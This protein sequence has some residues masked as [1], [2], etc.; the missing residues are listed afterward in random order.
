MKR[1][2]SRGQTRNPAYRVW[3]SMIQRC[4][5]PTD[6]NYRKYGARGVTVCDEWRAS[7]FAFLRDMGERPSKAHTLDRIDPHGNYEPKNCRWATWEQ[8][9]RNQ[10]TTPQYTAFGKT[11]S[12]PDWCDE[13]AIS[14]RVVYD[15]ITK[16]GWTLEDALTK[17]S[18]R[19]AAGWQRVPRT[20]LPEQS[21]T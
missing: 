14:K 5:T 20:D 10:R 4:Y 9:T 13:Y 21:A 19:S 2:V 17:Q 7:F 12:L 18:V 11:Q 15:R 3:A 6:T 16:Y 1:E 8:Q